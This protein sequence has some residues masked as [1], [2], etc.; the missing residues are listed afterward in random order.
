MR[1]DILKSY[2]DLDPAKVE[3]VYNGIDSQKVAAD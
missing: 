2:P 1:N 3:V